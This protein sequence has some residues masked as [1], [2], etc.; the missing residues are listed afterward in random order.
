MQVCVRQGLRRALRHVSRVSHHSTVAAPQL[1][2]SDGGAIV[3]DHVMAIAD[4]I[5]KLTL[6]ETGQL[7]KVLKDQ[8]G[9][10]K[11]N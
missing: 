7:T 11:G 8:L 10:L 5:C 9:L 2:S 4:Q 6:L 3:P 1:D